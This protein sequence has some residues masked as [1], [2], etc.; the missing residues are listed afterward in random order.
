MIFVLRTVN[1]G[2]KKIRNHFELYISF[3]RN[4]NDLCS[5]TIFLYDVDGMLMDKIA[6][7]MIIC[8][9]SQLLVH[10]NKGEFD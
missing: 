2:Q 5:F 7:V 9:S 6:L 8:R 3:L 10:L 4:T 1:D